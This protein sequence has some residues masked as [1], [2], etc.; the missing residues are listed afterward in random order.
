M[1]H[2]DIRQF[3]NALLQNGSCFLL[4]SLTVIVVQLLLFL[5]QVETR[6][7]WHAIEYLFLL[8]LVLQIGLGIIFDLCVFIGPQVFFEIVFL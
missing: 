6:S 2:Q 8:L 1:Q 7:K 4:A 3:G 5:V